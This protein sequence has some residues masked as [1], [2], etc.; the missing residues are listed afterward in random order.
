M[1]KLLPLLLPAAALTTALTAQGPDFLITFSQTE[2]T[3]SGS[4]GTSLQTLRPNEIA[5]LEYSNGPCSHLSAEKWAPRACFHA[6]AGDEDSDATYW[7]PAIFGSIDALLVGISPTPIGNANPR[8]VFFSPSL[9]MGAGVSVPDVL[10]PGDIGRIV[11]TSAGDG[12]IEYYLKQEDINT[13]LGLPLTWPIDVDAAAFAMGHGIFLSLDQDVLVQTPCG[14]QFLQDGA[15][16]MIPDWAITW[17]PD[18]R[19]AATLPNS[20]FVLYTEAQV[21]AM[22]Q[23][24]QVTDR[25]G[26]CLTACGDTEALE[27]DWQGAGQTIVP[28]AGAILQVPDL[29]FSVENGTGASVLTTAGGGQIYTNMCTTMGHACGSG[30]T[31]GDQSG[32]RPTSTAVGA[33]SHVNALASTWTMR[34][35]MEARTPVLNSSP[36]GLPLGA[37]MFDINSPAPLNWIFVTLVPSG[38]NAV[39]TSVSAF[40]WSMFG[41]PDYYPVPTPYTFAGTINGTATFPSFPIPPNFPVKILFQAVGVVNGLIELSTPAILDIQ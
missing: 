37:S 38:I 27:I 25:F 3:L 7:D 19:V 26:V 35:A 40:P 41:F 24:A 28:C 14:P 31:F 30:P 12:K 13:A 10:R 39:P 22:V 18:F 2:T 36:S 8:T 4:N 6:M 32:I 15:I 21:D 9:A 17:T 29:L 16:F 23:S 11:R 20:A 1:T 33:P 34:Y 5:H